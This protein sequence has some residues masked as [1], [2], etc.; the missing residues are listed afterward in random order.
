M[1]DNR[2]VFNNPALRLTKSPSEQKVRA[3]GGRKLE[4][5]RAERFDACRRR[6]YERVSQL[7]DQFSTLPR[8]SDRT[9]VWMQFYH[10]SA[11]PSHTPNELCGVPG[12][13]ITAPWRGGYVIELTEQG[14]RNLR[15]R[16]D[17]P[18]KQ[19]QI[20]ISNILNIEPFTS[21]LQ[22]EYE[23][24][25]DLA[26]QAYRDEKNRIWIRFTVAPYASTDSQ[27][28]VCSYL[29]DTLRDVWMLPPTE[30]TS[31]QPTA[32]DLVPAQGRTLALYGA[33]RSQPKTLILG[34]SRPEHISELLLSGS[35]GR[36]E[37]ITTPRSVSPGAGREPEELPYDLDR[38]PIIGV[39]DGGYH[40]NSY[41]NAVAWESDKLVTDDEADR[42]HGNMLAAMIVDA[43][44]WSN[45]LP[46]PDLPCRL[47]IVQAVQRDDILVTPVTAEELI[48]HL[49]KVMADQPETRV[50]NLSANTPFAAH[51]FEVSEMAHLLAGV[52]RKHQN[53]I[54][55]SSGN[56]E[57]GSPDIISPPADCD[58]ALVVA[59][60]S[61]TGLFE[62]LGGKCDISRTAFGPE[63][64]FKPD[65]SWFSTH[66]VLGGSI[67]RGSSFAAPLVSRLAAHC[68]EHVSNPTP[69]LVRGLILNAADLPKG[70]YDEHLG[71]GSPVL[72]N[73]PW[74]CPPNMVIMAWSEAMRAQQSYYWTDIAIPPSMIKNGR[75]VGRIRL[76][77]ILEPTVE[78]AG[79]EYFSLR[80]QSNVRHLPKGKEKWAG[81][82]GT[83]KPTT[84]EHK[85]RRE[86]QKWQP[87][88]FLEAQFTEKNGPFLEADRLQ[89][90][91]RLYWRHRFLFD[92]AIIRERAH[93]VTFVLTLESQNSDDDTY[94]EFRLMM[95]TEI[96]EMG[97]AI[98]TEV[99]NE[100]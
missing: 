10:D 5:Q 37:P 55:I 22:R 38:A 83:D 41:L 15:G 58:A 78:R 97:I 60:R 12:C 93:E 40:A 94:N 84:Y 82:L 79:D 98:E 31:D 25:S 24:H 54:V 1:A 46:I 28:A 72:I 16:I 32:R 8:F 57:L 66:R 73:E 13:Q 34:L 99:Q 77:A 63:L 2:P 68:F 76:I 86:E 30:E 74:N 81:L 62:A 35:I 4:K 69:D 45:S 96:E 52:C 85:A 91:A 67:V 53:L 14:L 80:I 9:L 11:A 33:G 71:Y 64:M 23:R 51:E 6:A 29:E 90:G 42:R 17:N 59:G 50:W 20:D 100:G 95:G 87:V 39:I 47:G 89:V 18:T 48:L 44:R 88:Q 61:T 27:S 49:D 92:D 7:L 56:R 26:S 21:A 36:W 19:A 70:K 75:L 65:L 43:T 3:S